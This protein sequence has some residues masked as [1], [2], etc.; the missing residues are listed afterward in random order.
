MAS[1]NFVQPAILRFDGHYDHWSMLME[2]FLRSKEYWPIVESGIQ[3]PT[4]NAVLTDAQKTELEGRKLKDLKEKDYL[5]QAI[6]R[7]ILETIL[8]K[9]TS[10]YIWDSM[11]KKYEGSARV[12]RAQ[13]QAL[14]R[15]F[16]TLQMKDGE[17]VTSYCAKTMEISNKMRFHGEKMEDVTILE[18]ILRSLTPK[19][20]YVV[21]SIEESKDIDTFSLDEL[22]SSLLVHEQKMNRSSTSEEQALKA[23]TFTHFSNSRG[24]GTGRGRGRGGRNNNE[25]GNQQQSHHQESK[26]QRREKSEA[27]VD[28]K[29]Y[30]A[31]VE[32]EV[33]CPINVLRTDRG[34]EYNSH[35]FANFC[36][37]HGIKR[38]LTAVHTP[39]QNGVCK[40][41]NHTIMNMVRNLLTTSGIPKSFW[42][43]VV[44][45][46]IHIL[47]RSPTFVVQNMTP[48]KAWS[49]RKPSVNHFQIFGCIAYAHITYEKRNKLDNKGE[50]CIFLGVSDKSKAYKLYSPSTMKIIISCDVVFDEEFTW[51]W[52]Q[53]KESILV[54]FDDEEKGQQPMED[55][56]KEEVTQNVP[57]AEQ[58][59]LAAES[60]R[61]QRVQ[62]RPTWMH[63]Y[64]VARI[65]QSEDP[66]NHFAL[67]SDCDPTSFEVAVTEPKWRKAMD[68]EIITIE[69][70]DTCELCDLQNGQKTIGVK[71]EFGVDYKEVYA[72]VAR[73]D[74]IRLVVAMAAQNSWPIFKLDV[75]SA[76]LHGD[77]K[78]EVFI[79]QP[80]SYEKLGNEHKVY[81]LKKAL[82]GLK[83]APQDCNIAMFESFKKSMMIEFEMSDLG[84]MHYFLGIEVLQS[85]AGIFISQKKYVGEILD[86][87]KMKD[88]NH[89]NAP[90]EFG[91]KL[92]K[93]EGGNKVNSTLYKQIIGS[94][95]YLTTTRLDIMYAV[96]AISKYMEC[97]TEIHLLAAKRI[98]RYLQGTKEFGLFFK[99]RKKSNLF[100]FT[101]SDYAGD[102]DDR[103]ST[104]GY[105]FMLGTGAVSWS[106]KKQSIV[107]LSTT[108]VEFVATIACA[109]QAIWLKK[110]LEELQFKEDGPTLIYCDNSSAIKLSKNPVLHDRSKHIDVKYHFLRDLMND[111]VI[112]LVYCRSED[113]IADI[114]TKP[115]KF[116]AFQKLNELLGV[117]SCAALKD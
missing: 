114:L 54:D 71:W 117:C 11:K 63:D 14:R 85:S 34:G 19:F 87:F 40:R 3:A 81:K 33:G 68:A 39:Q 57:I 98:L 38:Q 42:P 79:D 22:R 80:P 91:L 50:K 36:E 67:F 52:N 18:K 25:C 89:M 76:F 43:E 12:N 88:C 92:N 102:S 111:G 7:P 31:L 29:S 58:S 44:N 107:T 99:K 69:K 59:P 108:E 109:C 24:R 64:E 95:M 97:P 104:S 77:L 112:N 94:L 49:G 15:D 84:M 5:F 78:E 61:S 1:D 9:K 17:S 105:V 74:T 110:I 65:D 41:K 27:F 23:S 8:S 51:S 55:E 96:S 82:Y 46:S 100:G 2:N 48:E 90:S 16:E 37:N 86:K 28:F 70:N 45:W 35:E 60:Q 101:D 53:N 56:Q 30:K 20:D 32:K 47:N 62:R 13:L 115:L 10:K 106:S 93:D 4:P 75:K 72:P 113:Q 73:H 66:L 21:C 83:Q 26:F 116:P 6:N 103:K